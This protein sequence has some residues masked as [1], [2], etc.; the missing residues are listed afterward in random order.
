VPK[1]RINK[2]TT[3]KIIFFMSFPLCWIRSL[4]VAEKQPDSNPMLFQQDQFVN[5]K[6]FLTA[7]PLIA[8]SLPRYDSID[9]SLE[10]QIK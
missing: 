9:N 4:A 5:P 2:D 1:Q 8:E 7:I 3:A 6:W 10:P